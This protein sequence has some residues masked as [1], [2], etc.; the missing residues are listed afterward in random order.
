MPLATSLLA[1]AAAA[2]SGATVI[3]A[4]RREARAARTHPPEGTLVS[5]PDGRRVHA[6]TRGV[7]PDLVLIHGASGNLR[8]W[9]FRFVGL[10]EGRYRVTA[11]DRPG[12]GWSD[13]P[14]PGLDRPFAAEGASPAE[15]AAMLRAAAHA[16]GLR[17]PIL[18]GHSY[19]ASVA[20][21]WALDDPEGTAAV[22]NVAGATM[23]WPGRLGRLYRV[24]GSRLG[25]AV[26]PPL[27][28][29]FVPARTVRRALSATFAP[30]PE[31][32][33]YGRHFG[34]DLTLRARSL[35][36][37]ARQVGVLRRNLVAMAARYPSLA[38]PVEIVHGDA[39]TTVPLPIHSEPLARLIPTARLTVLPG[40]GHMPHHTAPE[41]VIAAIDRARERAGL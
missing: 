2:A 3:G 25:G 11:F 35:R 38:V 23:P 37:N 32:E 13:Q 31:P 18:L 26:V 4:R 15:Q 22:V 20:L 6:V 36:A 41:A 27:L 8:D 1:A 7:G 16:L 21:A 39:D 40:A 28:S 12:M 17:R 33:G 19:G 30:D 10:V 9:T 5:L 14:R 34:P 29:A 24:N